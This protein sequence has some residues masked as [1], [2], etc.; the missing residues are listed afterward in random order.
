MSVRFVKWKPQKN[1]REKHFFCHFFLLNFPRLSLISVCLFPIFSLFLS[2][3]AYARRSS[4]ISLI[5]PSLLSFLPVSSFR[6]RLIFYKRSSA[7]FPSPLSSPPMYFPPP[8]FHVFSFLCILFPF[9]SFR[10][11]IRGASSRLREYSFP[12]SKEHKDGLSFHKPLPLT[13]KTDRLPRFFRFCPSFSALF[14]DGKIDI[15]RL[16]IGRFHVVLHNKLQIRSPVYEGLK[17]VRQK[18]F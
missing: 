10:V 15:F 11:P 14:I 5:F 18:G 17:I 4:F 1:C 7:F 3:P 12:Y 16:F 9:S 2:L 6:F 8:F 13:E